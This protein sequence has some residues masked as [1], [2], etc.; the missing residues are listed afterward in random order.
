MAQEKLLTMSDYS[1]QFQVY[2]DAS[3][4]QLGAGLQQEG[5]PI[6]CSTRNLTDT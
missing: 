3:D 1:K 2:T 6:D 4:Y 5:K